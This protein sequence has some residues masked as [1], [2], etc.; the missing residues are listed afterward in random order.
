MT[1]QCRETVAQPGETS[2]SSSYASCQITLFRGFF[3]E[4]PFCPLV[5]TIKLFFI[6][7]QKSSSMVRISSKIKLKLPS[8]PTSAETRTLLCQQLQFLCLI[9]PPKMLKLLHLPK[10]LSTDMQ[11]AQGRFFLERTNVSI[12][13]TLYQRPKM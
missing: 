10:R 1:S 11:S 4:I 2:R 7:T 6:I 3:R 13:A 12:F 9:Q 5:F 8:L